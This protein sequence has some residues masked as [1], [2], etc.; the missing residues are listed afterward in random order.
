[1]ARKKTHAEYV[2]QVEAL[3]KGFTVIGEYQ[4]TMKKIAHQCGQ[5]HEWDASP[6]AILHGS[7]CPTCSGN[8]KKTHDEY[9]AEVEALGKGITVLGEYCNAKTKITHQCGEGH[10]W[11]TKPENILSGFDC[12]ICLGL[13]KK[14]H[15][16][17]VAELA[18][19][20]IEFIVI[21][22]YVNLK[23]KITHRC[24]KGHEWL[25]TPSNILRGTG[26]PGCDKIATDAN[27]FYIW[28]NAD[29][30]GVYKVG[31]TSERCG[32]GRITQCARQNSMTANII[33]V[34][35]VDDAREVERRAL[36][37]GD[38]PRYPADIDGY[39][40]F[41]RYSD[42]ELGAVYQMAVHAAI[43]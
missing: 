27:V 26:C 7:G 12:P 37:L 14:T 23:T 17:Y 6:N 19:N 24:K 38:D 28:E 42:A 32:D 29:D 3:N 21:G 40:E 8:K 2:A 5:G 10:H 18:M 16:E 11:D 35:A 9:I 1:M 4:N 25:A 43:A 13:K 33:L 34:A 22:E 20:S 15:E 36:D 41:R 30:P 39:T 31:I